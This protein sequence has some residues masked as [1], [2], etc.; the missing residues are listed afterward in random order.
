MADDPTPNFS[1]LYFGFASNLS[2]R[3]LQQRCP[4]ALYVGL[5]VLKQWKFIISDV[6][7]GNIVAGSS[8]DIV[9]GNLYFL[10]KQHED[11][12]DKSEEVPKWHRKLKLK[13]KMVVPNEA[14]EGWKDGQEVEAT[15]Y[16][17]TNHGS[18]GVISKEYLVWM[19]KA[20]ADGMEFSKIPADYFE[21]YMSKFLPEND[22]VGH[23]DKI[24]MIRT[25][26]QEGYK[27]NL[28]HVPTWMLK[29]KDK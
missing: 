1:C 5:A 3:T 10:T 24:V 26:E 21:R 9:Y 8:D 29:G 19:R 22:E 11:A 6:G 17:D 28:R 7:F 16:I 20:I 4:G 13:L 15:C 18:E 12:L 2:P 27:H 14:S 25:I 23:E